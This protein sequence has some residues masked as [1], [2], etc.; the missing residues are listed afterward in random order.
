MAYIGARPTT[1]FRVAPIKDTFTGDG[2]TTTFD[3]ANKVP[4]GGENA[5]QVFVENVRQEPGTGKAYTLGVDGSGDLKR[6]TFSS[7]PVSSAEIYVITSFSNEAFVNTDLNGNELVID[8]DGDTS[9][10]ADT[11]D[12][13]DIKIAGA[14]DFQF[15]ANTFTA[16]S[17]ST[18]AAQALTATTITSSS[19][20]DIQGQELI[21][22]ADNDTSITA[23][24]DDRIDV[25]IANTDHI[26]FGTSSGDTVIKP[27]TDAKDIIIQQFDGTS[28]VEF[29]DGAY[30]K[31]TSM[32]YFPEATL[33][34]ASTISWNVLTSPVAKVTLGA[35]RTLGAATGAQAGQFVSLLI[36]QDG[37]G[38]RTVTFNAAYEFKDDT[39]PTLTTTASKGDLFVFRYNG[40]KFLEVGRNLNLTLS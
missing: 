16:Q 38:S 23:D 27:M 3:L 28:L 6:I 1:N 20:V 9:I 30:S 14:D 24:T 37:T 36:I 32:A 19:T 29:N 5:L 10:T 40:S 22:D 11:D 35:N 2:S 21:L 33:T 13:I 25:K 26:S 12:Q 31:F 8:A 18:I 17:G 15:T 39:A 34:D 7:A 4:A